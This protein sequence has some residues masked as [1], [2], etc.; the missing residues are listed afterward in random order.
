MWGKKA[1][2]FQMQY[3]TKQEVTIV[4]TQSFGNKMFL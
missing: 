3:L 4:A 2:V 1:D